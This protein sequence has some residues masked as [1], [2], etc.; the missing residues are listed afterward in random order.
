[1]KI[2]ERT[3]WEAMK[4]EVTALVLR[5]QQKPDKLKLGFQVSAE[6]ILNAYRE[7][8]ISFA[9][10]ADLLEN[11]PCK[12]S[13]QLPAVKKWEYKTFEINPFTLLTE[14]NG[15]GRQGWETISIAEGNWITAH[16]FHGLIH[17]L[18]KREFSD[19]PVMPAEPPTLFSQVAKNPRSWEAVE[20]D[21]NSAEREA[22]RLDSSDWPLHIE[23][24]SR[25][26]IERQ[27]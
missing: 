4:E 9:D 5:L 6:G 2:S 13:Q 12:P 1:V 10:A 23:P 18:C 17:A 3:D 16:D 20:S 14:L 27:Q 15:L 7:G 25:A 8:D 22:R 24:G 11:L 21:E 26:D 19:E